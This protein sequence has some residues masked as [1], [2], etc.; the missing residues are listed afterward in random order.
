MNTYIC[1]NCNQEFKAYHKHRRYCSRICKVIG[2]SNRIELKCDN[3]GKLYKVPP[4]TYKWNRLR[5]YTHTFCSKQCKSKF[6]I[7]EGSPRWI[8]DRNMLKDKKHTIRFSDDMKNWREQIFKRDNYQCQICKQVGAS[9][10]AHHIK[11][12]AIYPNERFNIDNGITLC[13]I[14]HK[15]I[16]HMNGV[17][18]Q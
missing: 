13:T 8:K 5:N 2:T 6:H 7:R 14:C 16:H 9:L 11:P 17:N 4:S 18:N 3:C 1:Q 12:F 15:L 10:N